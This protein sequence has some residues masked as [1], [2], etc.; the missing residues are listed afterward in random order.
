MFCVLPQNYQHFLEKWYAYASLSKS[1]RELKNS[2]E[3]ISKPRGFKV[4]IKTVKILFWST[5]EENRLAYLDIDSNAF[6]FFFFF[7][8]V[9]WTIIYFKIEVLFFFQKGADNLR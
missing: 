3:I 7:F 5:T 6:F 1:S 4:W 8:W 9:P 2:I